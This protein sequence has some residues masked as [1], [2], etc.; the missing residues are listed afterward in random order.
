MDIF[1]M[2]SKPAGPLYQFLAI[3]LLFPLREGCSP[4]AES[5]G[6]LRVLTLMSVRRVSCAAG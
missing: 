2:L 6:D 1:C 3:P 4:S 5:V